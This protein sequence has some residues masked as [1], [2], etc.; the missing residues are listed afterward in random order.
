M[1]SGIFDLSKTPAVNIDIGGVAITVGAMAPSNVGPAFRALAAMLKKWQEDFGGALTTTGSANAY[2]LD[3]NSNPYAGALTYADGDTFAFIASFTNSGAATLNVESEGAKAI[4][5]L[6]DQALASGDIVSGSAYTVHYDASANGAAGAWLIDNAIGNFQPLDAS[7]TAYANLVTAANKF[8]TFS[9]SDT[10]VASDITAAALTLVAQATQ[11][12]MLTTGLGLSANG[13]SLVTAADYAAMRA[14]LDL[15]AGTD[16]YSK[17]AADAAF[18]PKDASLTAYAALVTA[19]NK[20]LTFSGADTPVAS[21][22]TADAL[23]LLADADVPRLSTANTWGADQT[24][25]DEVY[26]ATAWNGSLEVPTKNAVRDKIETITGGSGLAP[27]DATYYVTAAN[28]GL[29][30]EVVPAANVQSLLGAATFAA[31][32]ALLNLDTGDTP[33]FG[34][35]T[36]A[37]AGVRNWTGRAKISS[38]AD[39]RV[40]LTGQ[41][42]SGF[43]LLQFG[44][45]TASFPALGRSGTHL[46]AALADN[47]ATLTN[48]EVADEAYGSGWNGLLEVPTKNAVYDKIETLAPLAS[49]P[50]TGTPTIEATGTLAWVGRA[51]ISSPADG[52]VLLADNAGAGSPLLQFGGTTSA[53]PMLKRNGTVLE[54]HLAD[55]SA[56]TNLRI[57]DDF[58]GSGWDGENFA[59]TKNAIYDKIES[60]NLAS[61]TYVPTSSALSNMDAVT[62]L[63]GI[64]SRVGNTVTVG[65]RCAVNATAGG[66]ASFEVSLPVAS[67]FAA[68]SDASGI[69]VTASGDGSGIVAGSVA[70]NTL[71]ISYTVVVTTAV[72]MTIQAIYTVI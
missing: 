65:I 41:T 31:F 19:A 38:P 61:G 49:P 68:V 14:L 15:E 63:T 48:L 59:P 64:Y 17:T 70:N 35:T 39:Q 11:S 55:D 40:L 27:A 42:G 1:T 66:V 18:E 43:E 23:L 45:T 28:A 21:D 58:Y 56:A 8:L 5:K 60:L 12:L 34:G 46:V 47:I 20:F 3:T 44:G 54:V 69:A 36:L 71:T 57:I 51:K 52:R 6:N 22:I 32:R 4:R 26:D 72:T 50:F 16:F 53:F 2:L 37:A 67:N 7:L 30:D 13:Q 62:A 10:P 24:V 25:P 29:T 33:T 9:A